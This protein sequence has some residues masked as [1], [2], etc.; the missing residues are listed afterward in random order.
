MRQFILAAAAIACALPAAASA[1]SSPMFPH[2]MDDDI[3]RSLPHPYDVEEAGDRLG[4]AVGA[5]LNVPIGGVVQAIDPTARARR[6]D[7]IADVAGRDDPYFEERIEDDVR[8][9]TLKGA[10]LMRQLTVVA[11]VLRRSLADLERNLE[12]AIRRG[13]DRDYRDDY[14]R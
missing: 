10:D 2:E 11:P 6:N 4:S 5:I 12:G 9:L 3:A 7:T 1:Q 8:G 14:R 13:P